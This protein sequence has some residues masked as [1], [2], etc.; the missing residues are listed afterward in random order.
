M[1]HDSEYEELGT[2]FARMLW[3]CGSKMQKRMPKK[4]K[5]KRRRRIERVA[6]R[7]DAIQSQKFRYSDLRRRLKRLR[8]MT[9]KKEK[10]PTVWRNGG[11]WQA[12]R[13]AR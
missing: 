10:M 3:C 6:E 12:E 8:T 5:K 4:R 9:R 11:T 1:T 7:S 13:E 2:D